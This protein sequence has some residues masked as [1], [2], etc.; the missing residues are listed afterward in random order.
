MLD[1]LL[2]VLGITFLLIGLAGC[3]LPI[4]PGPP[5]SYAGLLMLHWTTGHQFSSDFLI[6]W[7]AVA[8]GVTVVDNLLPIW[9]TQKH[10][11]S[12]KAVWGSAVGLLIGLFLFPPFG[13]IIGPFVG[14][15][16][17][18]MIDGKDTLTALKSGAASFLGFI[19]GIILKLIAS[20]MMTYYFVKELI[21]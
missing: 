16:V 13:I 21:Y 7:A 9:A 14:A 17:G 18:E 10:G 8:I 1:I 4:L 3:V 15:V 19:G 20:G 5:L 2:I 11:G 12:K 6:F